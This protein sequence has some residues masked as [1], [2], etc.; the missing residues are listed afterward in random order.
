LLKVRLNDPDEVIDA[1]SAS[2]YRAQVEGEWHPPLLKK[3][4]LEGLHS[5]PLDIATK[6][7]SLFVPMPILANMARDL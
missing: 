6:F 2:E 7:K 5:I 3:P 4:S 1:L